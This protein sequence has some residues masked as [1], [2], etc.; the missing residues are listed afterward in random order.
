MLLTITDKSMVSIIRW[1]ILKKHIF[2]RSSSR[3]TCQTYSTISTRSM[4]LI[5]K[6]IPYQLRTIKSAF[7]HL[8][9]WSS[10][11][12]TF[13][14]MSSSSLIRSLIIVRH[15]RVRLQ[16]MLTGYKYF[17]GLSRGLNL[18]R[19]KRWIRANPRSRR[20]RRNGWK[21]IIPSL[22]LLQQNLIQLLD[23]LS[24]LRNLAIYHSSCV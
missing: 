9:K 16:I 4:V 5:P 1:K 22:K 20:M 3:N 19:Q 14:E 17:Y 2:K 15:S 21:R 7:H 24:V 13:H 11:W 12:D 10:V 23:G 18:L 6:M 8:V